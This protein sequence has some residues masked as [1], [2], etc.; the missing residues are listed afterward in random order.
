LNGGFLIDFC[1]S[2]DNNQLGGLIPSSIAQLTLLIYLYAR[3]LG[4]FPIVNPHACRF[5]NDNQMSGT[6]PSSIVNMKKL[7]G[8][9]VTLSRAR[10][11]S[12]PTRR[13]GTWGIAG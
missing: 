8:L 11:S 4:R 12:S 10:R 6:I 5:L 13:A 7:Q 9:C 2:L 3:K 1:R